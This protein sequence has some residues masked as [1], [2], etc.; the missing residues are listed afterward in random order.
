LNYFLILEVTFLGCSEP[1]RTVKVECE[2]GKDDIPLIDD[3]QN[4]N[5]QVNK[6]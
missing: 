1:K 4:K 5:S 3:P 6:S 2:N